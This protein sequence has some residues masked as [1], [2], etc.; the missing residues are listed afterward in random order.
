MRYEIGSAIDGGHPRT[1]DMDLWGITGL[2]MSAD[3]LTLVSMGGATLVWDVASD[4]SASRAIYVDHGSPEWPKVDVSPDGRWIAISGDGRRVVS[5]TGLVEFGFGSSFDAP[6]PCFPIELRFSPDGEW[7]AGA[8]W[9][10]A[11]DVFRMA[12]LEERATSG[13]GTLDATSSITANC[14]PGNPLVTG[15]RTAT[16]SSFTPDGRTLVTEAG[17]RYSTTDWQLLGGA[18]MDPA[19]HGLLGSFEVSVNGGSL[20]SDCAVDV[21]SRARDCRYGAPFPKYSPEG[22]W[23]VAGATLTHVSGETRVLDETAFVGIFAPNGDVIAAGA[24]NSLTRYCKVERAVLL[25]GAAHTG[26]ST[27]R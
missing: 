15:V 22:H 21:E 9:T 19:P 7:L 17:A 10:G 5:R 4:F 16:R 20:V 18:V 8:G 11:I 3:G 25:M 6:D 1:S 14:A 27:V 26:S 24:D 23:Y 2:A 13:G 12:D